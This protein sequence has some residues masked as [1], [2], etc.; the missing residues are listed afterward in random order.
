MHR[1]LRLHF[2][3]GTDL[4]VGSRY[5]CVHW[6]GTSS[7]VIFTGK[8][9]RPNR[10]MNCSMVM[11]EKLRRRSHNLGGVSSIKSWVGRRICLAGRTGAYSEPQLRLQLMDNVI[12]GIRLPRAVNL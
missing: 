11:N 2:L 6:S 7:S 3:I 10:K 8:H 5:R 1:W 4:R 9:C 12:T